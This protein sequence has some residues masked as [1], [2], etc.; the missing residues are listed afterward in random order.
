MQADQGVLDILQI[1]RKV[2]LGVY[3]P[4]DIVSCAFCGGILGSIVE[5]DGLGGKASYDMLFILLYVDVFSLQ[6][7]FEKG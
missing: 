3:V 2:M 6:Q 5:A 7:V 1:L 4:Q